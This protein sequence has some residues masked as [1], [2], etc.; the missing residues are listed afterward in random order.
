M[1]AVSKTRSV[2]GWLGVEPEAGDAMAERRARAAD[3]YFIV[4]DELGFV[5]WIVLEL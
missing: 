5:V 4:S 2:A 3:V 1:G